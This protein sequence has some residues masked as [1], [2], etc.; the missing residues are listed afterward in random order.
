MVEKKIIETIISELGP[1]GLLICGLYF[2]GGKH[3]DTIDRH[4]KKINEQLDSLIDA[5]HRLA[6]KQNG[7]N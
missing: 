2:I 3:M 7:K 4:I 5:L 6:D 1:T